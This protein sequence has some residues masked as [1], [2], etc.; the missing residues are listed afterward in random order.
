MTRHQSRA[1]LTDVKRLIARLNRGSI[2]RRCEAAQQLE[3]LITADVTLG[4]QALLALIV[5]VDDRSW[6]VREQV[7]RALAAFPPTPEIERALAGRMSLMTAEHTSSAGVSRSAAAHSHDMV[8]ENRATSLRP[9]P[10]S[11]SQP[12]SHLD[13]L[14]A[15]VAPNCETLLP[16]LVACGIEEAHVTNLPPEALTR[17]T[18]AI[19]ACWCDQLPLLLL[20]RTAMIIIRRYGLD[21]Q[22][23]ASQGALGRQWGVTRE[24]IRQIEMNGIQRLTLRKQQQRLMEKAA[25]TARAVLGLLDRPAV[26]HHAAIVD[27][28]DREPPSTIE[29]LAQPPRTTTYLEQSLSETHSLVAQ[30]MTPEQIMQARSVTRRTLDKHFKLLIVRGQIRVEQVVEAEL[31]ARIEEMIG[32]HNPMPSIATLKQRLP[33]TVSLGK[34]RCVIAAHIYEAR[35]GSRS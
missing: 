29:S 20:S 27:E 7:L 13:R 19:A 2:Q 31:I 24:R 6:A 12:V 15:A 34:I 18:K 16:F 8:E 5:A 11:T 1:N 25:A 10:L 28:H 22:A 21:G 9:T 32:T 33:A 30:G 3:L 23:P 14:V 4:R 26:E 17:L 35:R